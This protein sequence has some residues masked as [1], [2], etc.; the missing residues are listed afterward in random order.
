MTPELQGRC[1]AVRHGPDLS[2]AIECFLFVH[3]WAGPGELNKMKKL[4]L[5][6]GSRITGCIWSADPVC[7]LIISSPS[8]TCDLPMQLNRLLK[9][10]PKLAPNFMTY[11]R[12]NLALTESLKL[13][14]PCPL[15]PAWSGGNTLLCCIISRS[16]AWR[17]KSLQIR[18]VAMKIHKLS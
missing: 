11:S 6:T 13:V 1:G 2:K 15:A 12:Q 8:P 14:S 17:A 4:F 9:A 5:V 10:G 7:F 16:I 18:F 3:W